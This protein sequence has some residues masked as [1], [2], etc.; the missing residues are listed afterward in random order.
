MTLSTRIKPS[1]LT[2]L[3]GAVS[4]L[5]LAAHASPAIADTSD[6]VPAVERA[7]DEGISVGVLAGML[8][9]IATDGWNLQLEARLGRFVFDYSHG[10]SL[11]IPVAGAA[12]DQELALH[13]PYST[14]MGIGYKLT[15]ALDLRFEPK[16]HRFEV[17]YDGADED[18]VSYKTVTLGAGAYYTYKPFRD[19]NDASRGVTI[20]ASVRY[21]QNVW[22]SLDADG[23]AYENTRTGSQEVHE[24]SNIGI[25]NT[26][27]IINVSV[28]YVF[29]R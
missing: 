12:K 11:D 13:L 20:A 1:F 7:W 8:Q 3:L 14:G 18:L 15:S 9:P 2:P 23:F 5:A 6:P 4:V 22:S 27:F 17:G 24:T 25:G 10:W 21:W 16:L 28:G 26:P 29:E 19:R